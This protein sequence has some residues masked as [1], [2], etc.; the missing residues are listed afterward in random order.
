MGST[1]VFGFP[2]PDGSATP[3]VPYWL[4]QLA[5][6][7]EADVAAVD[8]AR[9]AT[10]MGSSGV[11]R[12][13]I[14]TA[15]VAALAAGAGANVTVTVPAGVFSAPPAAVAS[16]GVSSRLSVAVT[17]STTTSV[18]VRVDNFTAAAAGA[19]TVSV[20]AVGPAA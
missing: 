19:A 2:Y 3:D 16:P 20:I 12:A 8:A 14:G 1:P 15:N 9:K 11:P 5:E 13:W 17:G 10:V 6:S 18:T 4:Q 7:V